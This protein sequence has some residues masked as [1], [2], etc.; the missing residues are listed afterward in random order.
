MH[1]TK[2]TKIYKEKTKRMEEISNSEIYKSF[3]TPL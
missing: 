2:G 1:L 3:N